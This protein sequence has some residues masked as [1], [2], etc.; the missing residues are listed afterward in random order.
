MNRRDRCMESL[1]NKNIKKNNRYNKLLFLINNNKIKIIFYSSIIISIIIYLA[2]FFF[3]KGRL[4]REIFFDDGNDTFMDFFNVVYMNYGMDPI[5]KNIYPPFAA[6]LMLP[7]YSIIPREIVQ[8]GAFAMKGTQAGLVS[9]LLFIIISIFSLFIAIDYCKKGNNIEKKIFLG[10]TLLSM[11]FLFQFERQNLIIFSLIFLMAFIF[12]KDNTN[13]IVREI[14]LISLACSACIKFYPAIFGLIL[15]KEK[16]F[17]EAFRAIIYGVV[18]FI[19]PFFI[20]GGIGKL[21]DLIK[22]ILFTN[23]DTLSVG[24]GLKVDMINLIRTFGFIL[25][26]DEINVI[27]FATKFNY[28]VIALS[29]PATI[30][31]K[32]K[33]KSVTLLT[34]VI[35]ATPSFSWIYNLIYF[36]IPIMM[37]LDTKESRGKSDYFFLIPF[38]TIL[39]PVISGV[40]ISKGRFNLT[41]DG[42]IKNISVVYIYIYC[43]INGYIDMIKTIKGK[44][45]SK[46]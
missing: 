31:L 5:P 26:L 6:M 4:G 3:S 20:F 45:I 38:I 21:N 44:R 8:S 25:K 13:I 17:K 34:C 1:D 35:V 42:F 30:Y 9:L 32:S 18:I 27:N 19:L 37:F 14:A 2:I 11:P 29:I 40:F 16:R 28:L 22:N 39:I 41:Y 10:I 33:W 7:F 15:I 43:I 36:I 23:K 24:F 12:L 46:C